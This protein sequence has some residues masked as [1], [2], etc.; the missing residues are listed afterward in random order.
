MFS[1]RLPRPQCTRCVLVKLW[2]CPLLLLRQPVPCFWLPSGVH[3]REKRSWELFGKRS[4]PPKSDVFWEGFIL[5]E[6]TLF[7]M[8]WN[9]LRPSCPLNNTAYKYQ[10]SC[11]ET[12][13][14]LTPSK[15]KA[16]YRLLSS[17]V[18]WSA[19][20]EYFQSKSI[21]KVGQPLEACI[22][23]L[24]YF[25]LL[26]CSLVACDIWM[27]HLVVDGKSG[28]QNV[29]WFPPLQSSLE[30][31]DALSCLT[32]NHQGMWYIVSSQSIHW[33]MEHR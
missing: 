14:N 7:L 29:Q 3:Q 28:V 18:S 33:F 5:G 26:F 2:Q 22:F 30:S 4:C 32:L 23:F 10:Q 19:G 15:S 16:I 6:V 8:K 31:L 17:Y 24:C 27:L 13:S 11:R 1:S 9:C 21:F 20:S 12:P 25:V